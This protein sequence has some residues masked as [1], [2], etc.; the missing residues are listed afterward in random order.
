MNVKNSIGRINLLISNSDNDFNKNDVSLHT[1]ALVP[2]S[3]IESLNALGYGLT[4]WNGIYVFIP[5]AE[6]RDKRGEKRPQ[7]AVYIKL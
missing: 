3:E 5:K 1:L 2:I 4:S 7:A 6:E